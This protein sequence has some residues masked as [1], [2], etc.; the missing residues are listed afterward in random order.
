M[1]FGTHYEYGP[2]KST[3]FEFSVSHAMEALWLSFAQDAARGPKR[4]RRNDGGYF[5]WP[6]FEQG[7][8]DLVV[9]AEDGHTIQ[10]KDAVSRIDHY[11]PGF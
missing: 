8:D 11:C 1:L 4:F 5:A 2:G 3:P 6:A 10:L 9:F 7:N